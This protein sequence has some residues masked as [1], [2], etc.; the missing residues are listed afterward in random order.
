[1]RLAGQ[2][3][4]RIYKT[5]INAT[6]PVMLFDGAVRRPKLTG[7]KIQ[8][9]GVEWGDALEN[10]VPAF[11]I[12]RNC[13]YRVYDPHTCRHLRSRKELTVSVVGRSGRTLLVEAAQLAGVA[14]DW[15]AFGWLELGSGLTQEIL[16]VVSSSE[17]SG[18]RVTLTTS[19]PYR[20]ELPGSGV[21]LPGCDG[22][23]ST[24]ISKF[25][26][27]DNFGGHATP[28]TNLTLQAIKV[29]TEVGKK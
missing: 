7:R 3:R 5:T 6:E 2:L 8:A 21:L 12:Q 24:C 14:A 16:Y 27:L 18:N 22:R 13:N 10:P 11:F 26:N 25:N 20:G 23:R 1:M 4:L 17:A 29:T 9:T 28:R 19:A 15:Y